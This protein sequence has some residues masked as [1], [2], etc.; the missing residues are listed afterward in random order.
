MYVWVLSYKVPK[1][2]HQSIMS[3]RQI[4][5]IDSKSSRV[6]VRQ[7]DEAIYEAAVSRVQEKSFLNKAMGTIKIRGVIKKVARIH[8]MDSNTSRCW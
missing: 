1:L 4:A 6:S 2:F 5:G 7:A 3:I 8:I